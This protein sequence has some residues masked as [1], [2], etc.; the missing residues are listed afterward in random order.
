[1]LTKRIIPCLDVTLD[2]SG[3]TVVKGVEFVDLK[4]AGDPV[5]LAKRY[6]EQGADELVFLDIT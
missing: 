4:K 5:D 2:A 3:G 1:M 6:N